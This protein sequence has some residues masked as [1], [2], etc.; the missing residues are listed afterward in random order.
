MKIVN[1]RHHTILT[2]NMVYVGRP[3]QGLRSSPLANPYKDPMRELWE[4]LKDGFTDTPEYWIV[5][6]W[7]QRFAM[8]S[9]YKGDDL[10]DDLAIKMEDHGRT[11]DEHSSLLADHSRQLDA[12]RQG[13]ATSTSSPAACR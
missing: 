3:A 8:T 2:E 6:N 1:R 4:V 9:V 13:E 12:R 5:K 10:F 11:L 7:V